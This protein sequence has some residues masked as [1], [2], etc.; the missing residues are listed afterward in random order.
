MVQAY[1]EDSSVSEAGI[2]GKFGNFIGKFGRGVFS[3]SLISSPLLAGAV[4]IFGLAALPFTGLTIAG[5]GAGLGLSAAFSGLAVTAMTGVKVLAGLTAAGGAFKGLEALKN[6]QSKKGIK[7]IL[8]G[9]A[10][11]GAMVGLIA[12]AGTAPL[13]VLGITA[14]E[15]FSLLFKQT[16][17]LHYVGEIAGSLLDTVIGNDAPKTANIGANIAR[18]NAVGTGM[19]MQPSLTPQYGVPMGGAANSSVLAATGSTNQMMAMAP[20]NT[21]YQDQVMAERGQQTQQP[22][23][24]SGAEAQMWSDRA[25]MAADAAQNGLVG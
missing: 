25:N 6:G 3:T 16:S 5:A 13:A 2:L 1:L 12:L 10:Q 19:A 21:H 18:S 14:I 4:A 11:G 20:E 17:L 8:K 24:L 22:L 15:G 23:K 9:V 7:E